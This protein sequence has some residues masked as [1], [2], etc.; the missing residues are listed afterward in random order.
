MAASEAFKLLIENLQRSSRLDA[1]VLI[2]GEVGTGRRQ[3][4]LS[5]HKASRRADGRFVTVNCT[6][7]NDSRFGIE[8]FGMQNS[9]FEM[10]RKGAVFLAEEGTLY[11]H[12]VAEL[13]LEMQAQLVRYLESG[14]FTPVGSNDVI[15]SS[16]RLVCSTSANLTALVEAGRFRNDLYH[17]LAQM[18]INTPTLNERIADIDLLSAN[19]LR[20]IAPG[21]PYQLDRSA[22][23]RL[24][25]HSFTGNL[26]ELKN[27]LL[28]AISQSTSYVISENVMQFAITGGSVFSQSQ[29]LQDRTL[30]IEST[31][32]DNA[33]DPLAL[34]RS[35]KTNVL[36][37]QEQAGEPIV[38]PAELNDSRRK[39]RWAGAPEAQVDSSTVD[40]KLQE[41]SATS[42]SLDDLSTAQE[43]AAPTPKP[44]A[45]VTNLGSP[46]SATQPSAQRVKNET[47]SLKERE[48]LFIEELLVKHGGDKQAVANELGC[49][50]RTLY[51][52]IEK[53]K[54]RSS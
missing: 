25:S 11:L 48:L 8:L 13:T 29:D 28:R 20:E 49:T 2:N 51:R 17:M 41:F 22:Y 35:P 14:V 54:S 26:I 43:A 50:V 40:S 6:A 27:I 21:Q 42:Q 30:S 46:V 12:E 36:T 37:T 18:V 52:K 10:V 1:N 7:L 19:I 34:E 15:A 9:A 45:V 24:L 31:M 4:A 53:I 47:L 38:E 5:I 16:V 44:K 3:C 23:N 33:E 32:G 39:G